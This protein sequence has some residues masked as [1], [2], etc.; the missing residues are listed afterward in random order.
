MKSGGKIQELK[1]FLASS[2]PLK[3]ISRKKS[4]NTLAKEPT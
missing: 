1:P 2:R 3:T 4:N